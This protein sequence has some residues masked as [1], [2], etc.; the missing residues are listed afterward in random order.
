MPRILFMK[1]GKEELHKRG[2]ITNGRC[3]PYNPKLVE[4]AKELRNNMTLAERKLW[5]G[6]LKECP[7]RF[8]RQMLIDNFIVDF[9]C[10]SKKVVIEID[11]EVHANRTEYDEDRSGILRSYGLLVV[12]FT[13][14]EVINDFISVCSK[15]NKYLNS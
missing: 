14:S 11:G 13:N 2:L 1:F 5:N 4:R 15:I 6:L 9:Y 3:M 8:R 12:R 7:Y 10:A